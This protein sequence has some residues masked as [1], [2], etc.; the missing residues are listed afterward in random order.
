[1][2]TA[3]AAGP[4]RATLGEYLSEILRAS[5]EK[6]AG[7]ALSYER[8]SSLFKMLPDI[9]LATKAHWT[10][11]WHPLLSAPMQRA[12]KVGRN[13]PCPC[14]SGRSTNAAGGRVKLGAGRS[15]FAA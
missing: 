4:L 2:L 14:G 11:S 6:G 9:A 1:V 5:G 3:L 7:G 12:A 13:D 15:S 8:R 10:G